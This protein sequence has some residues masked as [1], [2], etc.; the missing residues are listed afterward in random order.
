MG[1]AALGF[2]D[3]MPVQLVGGGKEDISRENF[4]NWDARM[5]KWPPTRKI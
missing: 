1:L 3:K 4:S 2:V 5:P